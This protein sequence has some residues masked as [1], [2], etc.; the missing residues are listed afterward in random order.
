MH[1]DD[2]FLCWRKGKIAL[3]EAG[4]VG[5]IFGDQ[6]LLN[7]SGHCWKQMGDSLYSL[8]AGKYGSVFDSGTQSRNQC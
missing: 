6:I 5:G 7:W 4:S 2:V 8:S 3:G 1:T